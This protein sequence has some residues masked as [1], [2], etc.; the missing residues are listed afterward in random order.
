MCWNNG[1]ALIGQNIAILIGTLS[2]YEYLR[3]EP[4]IGLIISG[5]VLVV[6][7]LMAVFMVKDPEIKKPDCSKLVRKSGRKLYT[8]WEMFFGLLNVMILSST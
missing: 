3:M 5:I 1:V 4:T 2:A 6:V 8:S 7:A